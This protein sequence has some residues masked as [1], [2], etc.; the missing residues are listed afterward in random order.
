MINNKGVRETWHLPA[1]AAALLFSALSVPT[2]GQSS[3]G[4]VG[5][6]TRDSSSGKPIAKAQIVAR[7]LDKGTQRTTISDA[8]GIFTFT[9]L[10]PGPYEV[11]ATKDGF[12][13]SR[14]KSK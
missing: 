13:K 2:F 1:I 5:G 3:V 6:I 14:R 10:E 7:N 8:D 4:L 12:G 11:A 9:N